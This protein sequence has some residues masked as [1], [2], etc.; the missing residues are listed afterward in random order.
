MYLSTNLSGF[1]ILGINDLNR[2]SLGYG[3]ISYKS[4]Q[5]GLLTQ[6]TALEF[7]RI[8]NY[9]AKAIMAFV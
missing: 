3:L 2:G 4:R 7:V 8:G 1:C 9:S 5:D 6:V